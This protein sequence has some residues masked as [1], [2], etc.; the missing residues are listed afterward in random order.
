MKKYILLSCSPPGYW[1]CQCH[2]VLR[3]RHPPAQ[4]QHTQ[5]YSWH[6]KYVLL[7][8]SPPITTE[9][10]AS[11]PSCAAK[12]PACPGSAQSASEA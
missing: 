2:P 4:T 6:D 7:S 3:K 11:M 1:T 5:W 9:S 12:A 10:A 8:H